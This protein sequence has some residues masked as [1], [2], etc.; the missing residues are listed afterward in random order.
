MNNIKPR[1][2]ELANAPAMTA[3]ESEEWCRTYV[4]G[5][6]IPQKVWDYGL[7]LA[8]QKTAELHS[9]AEKFKNYRA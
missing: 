6:Y 5:D 8:K 2:T 1:L 7:M 3:E 9:L 4:K